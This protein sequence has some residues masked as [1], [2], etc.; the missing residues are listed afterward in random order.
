MQTG[1]R[2]A[3]RL[4][5]KYLESMLNQ[6]IAFFDVDAKTGETV[7]NISSDTLKVQDAISE[8]VARAPSAV[9]L[10]L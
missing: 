7:E 4:R 5:T 3:A 2:Q 9:C 8:K 6:D 10:I 1:E